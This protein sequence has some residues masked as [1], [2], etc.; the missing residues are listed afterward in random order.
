MNESCGDERARR[1]GR[2]QGRSKAC[3]KSHARTVGV[4]AVTLVVAI[5]LPTT[6]FGQAPATPATDPAWRFRRVFVPLKDLDERAAGLIAFPADQFEAAVDRLN[7]QS[8][9]GSEARVST[10]ETVLV[11]RHGQ[12]VGGTVLDVQDG[13]LT[14]SNGRRAVPT[15]PDLFPSIESPPPDPGTPRVRP[16]HGHRRIAERPLSRNR[17]GIDACQV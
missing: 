5:G 12:L 1:A 6:P 8:P 2:H 16:V 3:W 17:G 7:T 11:W 13:R 10:S 9:L 4:W 15:V 14:G